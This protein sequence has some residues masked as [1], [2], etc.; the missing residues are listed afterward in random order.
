MGLNAT[1][2]SRSIGGRQVLSGISLTLNAGEVLGLGG[3]SG[4]GKSTLGRILAGHT[5]PERGVIRLDDR[6]TP[7]LGMRHAPVQYAPQSAELA[8]DPRWR[9]RDV[10]CNAGDPDE[11]VLQALEIRTAWADRFPCELSGGE[12]ARVSLARM[13]GPQTRF[14]ICDEVTA[15]LDA[16]TQARLWQA[17]LRLAALRRLGLLVIS[18]DRHLRSQIC[19]RNL[20][21]C[22][23][24]LR[25]ESEIARPLARTLDLRDCA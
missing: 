16:L 11:A 22:G 25:E 6:L 17:L 20:V 12:L 18:H 14:L 9:V 4:A 10:L 15:Q 7:P 13:L 5:R 24:Q 23:G 1:D 21:L 2:I 19:G 8:C 3:V